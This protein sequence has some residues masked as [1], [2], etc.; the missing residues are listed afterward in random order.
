MGV[1]DYYAA[2][3]R[4][5]IVSTEGGTPRSITDSFDESVTSVEWKPD[6][7]YFSALQKTASH[8]FRVNP[9]TSSIVRISAPDNL[10]ARSFSFTRNGKQMAFAAS[11]PVSLSEV[12]VSDV[13]SF[14]P[15]LLTNMT[16]QPDSLILGTREVISWKS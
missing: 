1:I 13:G 7:I 15:H 4:L 5:A 2:T 3:F 11:S 16:A 12:F 14:S 10:I 9:F 6:G 8:L